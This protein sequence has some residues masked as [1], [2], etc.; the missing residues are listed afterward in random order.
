MK[1]RRCIEI[2]MFK[3]DLNMKDIA[4]RLDVDTKTVYNWYNYVEP[5]NIEFYKRLEKLVMESGFDNEKTVKEIIEAEEIIKNVGKKEWKDFILGLQEKLN[6]EQFELL[7]K[8]GLKR[9]FHVSEW[10]SGK[11][12][13][14]HFQR[15]RFAGL[16]LKHF[17]KTIEMIMF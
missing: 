4:S 14:N 16:C 17:F 10:I 6:L 5:R 7:D 12:I 8:A 11:R 3:A 1:A 15:F 2:L 13:P 9:D